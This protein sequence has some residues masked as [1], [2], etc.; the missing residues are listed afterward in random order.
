MGWEEAAAKESQLLSHEEKHLV[1]TYRKLDATGK[2]M[3][4][5]IL[6]FASR[7]QKEAQEAR[8]TRFAS[9]YEIARER[10]RKEMP[11]PGRASAGLGVSAIPDYDTI[12][13]PDEA[14][15]AL[16][17]EG[18]SMEPKFHDGDVVYLREQ[19]SLE[20][21][22][23]GVV[24]IMGS[25]DFVPRAYLK[26]LVQGRYKTVVLRSLNSNYKDMHVAADTIRVLG[27]VVSSLSPQ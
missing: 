9:V 21:Y 7:K 14:D 8:P 13:G 26:Q 11:L 17:V 23:I 18:D 24:Q 1:K 19:P 10:Y 4:D 15:F 25:H 12:M 6:A 27:K 5:D 2:K 20:D 16:F 22:E 3:V